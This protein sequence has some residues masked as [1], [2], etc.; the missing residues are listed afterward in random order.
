MPPTGFID[1]AD[2]YTERAFLAE[3]PGLY[4]RV[5]FSYRPLLIEQILAFADAS[6]P[7]KGMQ[8]RQLVAGLLAAQLKGW[9]VRDSRGEVVAVTPANL[10][11]LK[12]PLFMRLWAVVSCDGPPDGTVEA[13]DGEAKAAAEDLLEGARSGRP[14]AEVREERHRKN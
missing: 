6:R 14:V 4:A 3:Q 5:E 2:G 11:R 10:L 13:D 8:V 12:E 9:D 7:L 1:L